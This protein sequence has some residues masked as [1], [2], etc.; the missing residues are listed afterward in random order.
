[1]LSSPSDLYYV[2]GTFGSE[3]VSLLLDSGAVSNIIDEELRK[4]VRDS[5]DL[6]GVLF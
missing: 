4:V 1:M 3:K 6:E 2:N 5:E